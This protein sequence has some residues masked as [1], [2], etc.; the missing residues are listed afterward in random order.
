MR[1][2]RIATIVLALAPTATFGSPVPAIKDGIIASGHGLT[3]SKT[4]IRYGLANRNDDNPPTPINTHPG[5]LYINAHVTETCTPNDA[6][7]KPKT[8]RDGGDPEFTCATDVTGD[9]VCTGADVRCV[10]GKHGDATCSFNGPDLSGDDGS[11]SRVNEER[12]AAV[13][14]KVAAPESQSGGSGEDDYDPFDASPNYSCVEVSAYTWSCGP[15]GKGNS[16]D[17]RQ[18]GEK[19]NINIEIPD[20]EVPEI[21][22]PRDLNITKWDIRCVYITD[23]NALPYPTG[24]GDCLFLSLDIMSPNNTL[25]IPDPDVHPPSTNPDDLILYWSQNDTWCKHAAH[26]T[27]HLSMC[28]FTGG[29]LPKHELKK[30]M[31][32]LRDICVAEQQVGGYVDLGNTGVTLVMGALDTTEGIEEEMDRE[33]NPGQGM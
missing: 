25:F 22:S 8:K 20:D 7:H 28:G 33:H 2:S 29:K 23:K 32:M 15:N 5:E 24:L 13:L 3:P 12:L 30:P 1:A 16:V 31:E 26:N 21:L 4:I 18:V 6:D 17:A 14:S 10:I 9:Y 11:K 27:C 19:V